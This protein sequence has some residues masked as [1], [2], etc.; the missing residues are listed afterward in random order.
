MHTALP[1]AFCYYLVPS[2]GLPADRHYPPESG[3]AIR[4]APV[5]DTF[6]N[7]RVSN[8]LHT[9]FQ[10]PRTRCSPA[11]AQP[12]NNLQSPGVAGK[13]INYHQCGLAVD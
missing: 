5:S 13:K 4:P 10:N 6:E 1:V 2:T 7:T 8:I 3:P 9:P 12:Y 11:A